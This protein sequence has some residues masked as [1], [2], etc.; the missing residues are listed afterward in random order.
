MVSSTTQKEL[1]PFFR[2]VSRIFDLTP[3]VC[4]R[5]KDLIT[6]VDSRY[7]IDISKTVRD[8]AGNSDW[9]VESVTVAVL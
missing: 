1:Y 4:T 8:K 7:L 6:L 5:F 9:R 2:G 3:E